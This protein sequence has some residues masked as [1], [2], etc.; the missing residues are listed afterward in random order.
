MKPWLYTLKVFSVLALAMLLSSCEKKSPNP[1]PRTESKSEAVA[2]NTANPAI[3][4][5]VIEPAPAVSEV[6]AK[7]VVPTAMPRM[8][9]L[10]SVGCRPCD[11][12]A[13]ILD[14]LRAEYKG[15]LSVEFFDV[16]KDPAPARQYSIK[17]IPTQIFLD[18][19]GKEIFRHEG[20][21]AKADILPIL[22]QMGVKI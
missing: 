22:A 7:A 12:M 17:L 6:T 16:R 19:S 15:R 1:L 8:L 14:E 20:F 13:P 2:Q 3:C 11:A 21:F 4:D 10:G 5:T 9:E 18:A